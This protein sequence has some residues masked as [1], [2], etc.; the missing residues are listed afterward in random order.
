MTKLIAKKTFRDIINKKINLYILFGIWL[1][2]CLS[3]FVNYTKFDTH[4]LS[5][6]S[7]RT[8][9]REKWEN[10]PD[11][12]PH[13]MAHYGYLVF[14]LAHPMSIFDNGLDD[15]LGN[16]IFLEAHKQNT[17]NISEANSSGV[18]VRFGVFTPAFIF[19][20]LLPLIIFFVG[21]NLITKEK[22]ANTLKLLSIQGAPNKSIIL[23]KTLGLW[24]YSLMLSLPIFPIIIGMISS[25]HL[26]SF[27]D[28]LSRSLILAVSYIVFYFLL[29]TVV[30]GISTLSK[31]SAMAL[32]NLI[33][34]WLLMTIILPKTVQY[35]AQISY[36]TESRIAFETKLEKQILK[37]G[38]SHNPNDPYF[39]QIK[40]SLLNHYNVDNVNKLPFNYG[41][42]IMKQGE[43]ISTSI[44][45]K[46]IKELENTFEKQY[47]ITQYSSYLN[48][49]TAIKN[50]STMICATDYYSY[51]IFQKQAEDYRYQLAQYMNDLQIEHISNDNS[52]SEIISKENWKNLPDFNYQY[53]SLLTSLQT[54]L[55]IFFA[56]IF[57]F[58]ISLLI[59]SLSIKKLK[60]N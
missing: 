3:C 33:T 17:A 10:R 29:S 49:I 30:I 48:P 7:Y 38:D 14:R 47:H 37:V 24:F 39:S 13:R 26:S 12:H 35:I 21:F 44:Y 15:Y 9:V 2:F 51:K 59:I 18:L 58:V 31:S 5:V 52:K 23:G 8:E 41:G 42:F 19:Q 20:I 50:F 16:V 54:Q 11:K 28:I 57:W 45:N 36:P 46:K 32:I 56:L 40:D 4:A 6:E 22:E 55:P 60:F 43:K 27:L 25:S 53:T 34:I 1:I